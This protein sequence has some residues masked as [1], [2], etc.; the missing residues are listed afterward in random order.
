MSKIPIVARRRR[1]QLAT[2]VP[3]LTPPGKP[4][5]WFPGEGL[6]TQASLL[7]SLKSVL[8][9]PWSF[10]KTLFMAVAIILE[11]L[12]V[13][14]KIWSEICHLPSNMIFQHDLMTHKSFRHHFISFLKFPKFDPKFAHFSKFS[15]RWISSID[16]PFHLKICMKFVMTYHSKWKIEIR[17]AIV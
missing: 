12:Y 17:K 7:S 14:F 8:W 15:R 6:V 3:V 11:F 16:K 4:S 10:I 9:K 5:T 1:S 2:T 13:L